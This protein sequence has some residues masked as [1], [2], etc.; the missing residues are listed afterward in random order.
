MDLYILQY[1]LMGAWFILVAYSTVRFL[2][3]RFMFPHV[4]V[5]LLVDAGFLLRHFPGF[6]RW[7]F[8]L[9]AAYSGGLLTHSVYASGMTLCSFPFL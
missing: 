3:T 5:S 7:A 2:Y 9:R 4:L 1:P 6:H 8:G